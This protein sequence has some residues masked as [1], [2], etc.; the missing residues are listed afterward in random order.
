MDHWELGFNSILTPVSRCWCCSPDENSCILITPQCSESF[1]SQ[2][3]WWLLS[4]L[5]QTLF[6]Q[7]YYSV[8]TSTFSYFFL[9]HHDQN[10]SQLFF[11]VSSLV[12]HF[13]QWRMCFEEQASQ[14]WR[15]LTT[16]DP[17]R[18]MMDEDEAPRS[19]VRLILQSSQTGSTSAD[20]KNKTLT[21]LQR[22]RW[23]R[24]APVFADGSSINTDLKGIRCHV[25]RG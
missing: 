8:I 19:E 21:Q 17:D 16:P 22:R 11:P 24:K 7:T 2:I 4:D 1:P 23:S 20:R 5:F 12:V 6:F 13:S 25:N 18:E 15:E 14:W 9:S 10:L 3:L